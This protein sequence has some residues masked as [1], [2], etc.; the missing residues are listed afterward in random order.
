VILDLARVAAG[1][2]PTQIVGNVNGLYVADPGSGRLWR[3]FGDPLQTGV[4]MQRGTKGV[5]GPVL[6]SWQADVLYALDDAKKVWRAEGDQI[7]D[8]TPADRDTWKTTTDIALFTSNLYVLDTASGQLWK[9]ESPDG[10]AFGAASPYLAA[11]LAP[12]TAQSLA[13]DGDVWIVT[14]TGEIVRFRRNPLATTAV[15]IDFAPRWQGDAVHPSS[16]QAVAGQTNVYVLDAAGRK[17]VQ[18]ARDGRELLRI[19]LPATLPPASAFYV[20]EVARVAYT[21]HGSKIV[22]TA[23]DR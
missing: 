15:R 9:H 8:V 14:S 16:I 3:V 13:V 19:D 22:T 7:R 12:N 21:V 10:V 11:A 2:K 6:V 23:L 5:A 1:A 4:V 18:L 20:S 17:I